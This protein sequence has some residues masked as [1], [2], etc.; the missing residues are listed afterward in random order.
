MFIDHSVFSDLS[1]SDGGWSLNPMW[2]VCRKEFQRSSTGNRWELKC[3]LAE[4]TKNLWAVWFERRGWMC[5]CIVHNHEVPLFLL[6]LCCT[7]V[8]NDCLIGG[9]A[10][11]NWSSWQVFLFHLDEVGFA[12]VGN[13]DNHPGG[14]GGADY[15]WHSH[16]AMS[17]WITSSSFCNIVTF[18]ELVNC[19]GLFPYLFLWSYLTSSS[20]YT[21]CRK[22]KANIWSGL[23][24]EDNSKSKTKRNKRKEISKPHQ[25]KLVKE[26]TT[27][28]NNA[29]LKT[30]QTWVASSKVMVPIINKM[31]HTG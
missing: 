13:I 17:L 30:H 19:G 1:P 2:N 31:Y 23:E 12:V 21:I 5:T 4:K 18:I 27:L 26:R 3:H 9:R 24:G 14:G 7:A 10:S 16:L 6:V 20:R 22:I 15:A 11:S 28:Y 29:Q 25:I 8:G